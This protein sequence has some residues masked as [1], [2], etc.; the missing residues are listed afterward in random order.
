MT[1]PALGE[2][3]R[4]VRFLLTKNHPVP[5]IAFRTGAPRCAL[6][7]C[8]HDVIAKLLNYVTVSTDTKLCNCTKKMRSSLMRWI[9]N[10]GVSCSFFS[11]RSNT[12]ERAP[13]FTDRQT[14]GQFNLTFQKCLI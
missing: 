10:D 3:I 4:S 13:S 2:V 8:Y 6:W 1:S 14:D 7:L 5:T 12:L 11:I 9:S